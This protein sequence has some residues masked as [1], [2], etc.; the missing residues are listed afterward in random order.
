MRSFSRI[1]Y[2]HRSWKAVV[3]LVMTVVAGLAQNR[4]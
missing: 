3:G 1:E 4:T 2:V